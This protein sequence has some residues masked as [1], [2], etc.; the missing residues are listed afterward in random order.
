MARPAL[1]SAASSARRRAAVDGGRGALDARAW[2]ADLAGDLQRQ[3]RP[4]QQAV[5][6]R[7]ALG[8]LQHR[9]QGLCIVAGI[10]AGQVRRAAQR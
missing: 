9:R 5:A 6:M 2:L 8:A 10:A 7:A 3:R 4:E 1:R